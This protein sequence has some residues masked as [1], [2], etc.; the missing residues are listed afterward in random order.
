MKKLK[1]H[2]PTTRLFTDFKN[3][4]DFTSSY[5]ADEVSDDGS[6]L[7]IHVNAVLESGKTSIVLN[8]FGIDRDSYKTF[9][10]R[11]VSGDCSRKLSLCESRL[12]GEKPEMFHEYSFGLKSPSG[13]ISVSVN[14]E[15]IIISWDTKPDGVL[16]E[17]EKGSVLMSSSGVKLGNPE[18]ELKHLEQ[19]L[20]YMPEFLLDYIKKKINKIKSEYKL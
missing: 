14:T 15:T 19:Q 20:E 6:H 8:V 18:E 2:K 4:G 3:S 1:L 13:K 7:S 16:I 5:V 10:S 9:D 17:H 12:P 11:V